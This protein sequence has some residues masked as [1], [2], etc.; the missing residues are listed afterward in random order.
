MLFVV[1]RIQ[2]IPGIAK[3]M[4]KAGFKTN[5]FTCNAVD[6]MGIYFSPTE[7]KL[8]RIICDLVLQSGRDPHME[9]VRG[10]DVLDIWFDSGVSWASVLKGQ[11]NLTLVLTEKN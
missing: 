3:V 1:A 10:D 11:F 6:V 9:Y 4:A 5:G 7:I 2:P 8:R